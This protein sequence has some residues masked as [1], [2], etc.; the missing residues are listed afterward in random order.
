M[1]KAPGGRT[2]WKRPSAS[3]TSRATTLPAASR[4]ST[5]A[6]D[7][8]D[9][10][11]SPARWG[12]GSAGETEIVPLTPVL[13][14]SVW[15]RTEDIFEAALP[16]AMPG[17]PCATCCNPLSGRMRTRIGNTRE[18]RLASRLS[19]EC[20][21]LDKGLIGWKGENKSAAAARA[22]LKPNL[23]PE[24]LGNRVVVLLAQIDT[25]HVETLNEIKKLREA[26]S[27]T[28]RSGS[29]P[30]PPL[31]PA[32]PQACSESLRFAMRAPP[33]AART[34]RRRGRD[35]AGARRS[36]PAFPSPGRHSRGACVAL[37]R[38]RRRG[39]E[40]GDWGE[41]RNSRLLTGGGTFIRRAGRQLVK[42]FA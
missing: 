8:G 14:G 40:T 1:S 30:P 25:L 24:M 22:V 15:A 36:R 42:V 9:D 18:R 27:E 12:P 17:R 4:S 21:V 23:P 5:D 26:I 31:T 10:A 38:R 11:L 6:P 34:S 16:R 39:A 29:D 7:N 2:T 33:R 28:S 37:R 19:A 32:C 41:R 13:T 35:S 3:V 20:T